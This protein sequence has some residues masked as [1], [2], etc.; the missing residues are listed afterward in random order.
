MQNIRR[1][2][3]L[4]TLGAVPLALAGCGGGDD[5][6]SGTQGFNAKPMVDNIT[7]NVIVQ[8]YKNLNSAAAAL[9]TAVTTLRTTPNDT[10]L[11]AA[12]NAWRTT[13]LPWERSEGFLFGPV[14]DEEIDPAIDS[15]PLDTASLQQF[16]AANPNPSVTLIENGPDDLRGFHAIEY[17]LF[18]DG[19]STNNKP[20]GALTTPELN[21]LVALTQAL[22]NRT[23]V[24]ED[25]WTVGTSAY[26]TR[27]KNPGTSGSV[28]PSYIGVLSFIVDG[29]AN[30]ANEVGNA[31]MAEPLGDTLAQADTSKV[32]SQYSWNSLTDFH[33][34]LQSILN[35][36]TGRLGFNPATQ[37]PSASD[38][39]LYTFV[40]NSSTSAANAVYDKIL[41]AQ[42]KIALI[43]G[44]NDSTST[45]ITGSAQP[46]RVQIGTV[47]G[48]ALVTTAIAACNT[49]KTALENDVKPL[50]GRTTFA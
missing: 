21:Y 15:W 30:I 11:L 41:D 5:S 44:D 27:F 49:L 42:R 3:I 38:N 39:G 18:G 43:K 24:L 26:A 36:Y 14:S 20:A 45:V 31:K 12:Q 23:Q 47:A 8:T 17:V 7:D 48:R 9:Q 37:T 32:E 1:R 34:N 10:N 6:D 19:V 2:D 33:N 40:A 25:G 35:V 28:H 16:L 4:W 46:F 22:K 29:L 13:R 50:I